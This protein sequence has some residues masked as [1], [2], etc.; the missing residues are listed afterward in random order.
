[1]GLR[2]FLIQLRETGCV[3]LDGP[4][5]PQPD[6]L[7]A[8]TEVL[9]EMDAQARMELSG[10]PPVLDEAAAEWAAGMLY[11]ACQLL[12]YR[13]IP[14]EVVQEDLAQGYGGPRGPSAAY[15]ADLTFRYLPDALALARGL[16]SGDVL[17]DGLRELCRQWPLSSV[18][19][20]DLGDLDID[21]FIDDTSLRQLYADRIL[22][23]GDVSRAADARVGEAIRASL[24][25][26]G[27]LKPAFAGLTSGD[28]SESAG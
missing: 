28:S 26:Y 21:G 3:R 10:R 24:G 25:M 22:A 19:V 4:E 9:T 20:A 5:P 18:G 13:D 17:V 2:E 23:R 16:A 6:D 15:S 14:A 7:T 12:A 27:Q 11:R 1:M 8:A